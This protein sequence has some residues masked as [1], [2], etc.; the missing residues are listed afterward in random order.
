M[1]SVSIMNKYTSSHT[2]GS[3]LFPHMWKYTWHNIMWYRLSLTRDRSVVFNKYSSFL[4]NQ[5]H[6]HDICTLYAYCIWY[7]SCIMSNQG[8]K[9]YHYETHDVDVLFSNLVNLLFR[10]L[11]WLA[12]IL[13]KS[14]PISKADMRFISNEKQIN[15]SIKMS[16]DKAIKL[17]Y[18]T[19]R[20]TQFTE[21]HFPSIIQIR[22]YLYT[23]P[24]CYKT[25]IYHFWTKSEWPYNILIY[26]QSQLSIFLVVVCDPV[27]WQHV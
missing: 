2:C 10:F 23:F 6:R 5:T 7:N 9:Q 24:F 8:Y 12:F 15:T 11:Q 18:L 26:N 21:W 19:K 20:K 13:T 17:T 1:Q 3:I 16:Y 4:Q 14:K 22:P 25:T 27:D